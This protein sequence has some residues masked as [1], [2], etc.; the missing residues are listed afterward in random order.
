MICVDRDAKPQTKASNK[1]FFYRKPFIM[2]KGPKHNSAKPRSNGI[3]KVA[4]QNFKS[5]QKKGKAKEITSNLKLVCIILIMGIKI[6]FPE[7]F[8]GK[9]LAKLQNWTKLCRSFGKLVTPQTNASTVRSPKADKSEASSKKL[10]QLLRLRWMI[11]PPV[12]AKPAS[13][14]VLYE[15]QILFPP[16]GFFEPAQQD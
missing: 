7:S 12:S 5:K 10:S 3:F 13:E 15:I 4:G 1:Y 16:L 11:W 2:G 8:P 14:H 6:L 9:T